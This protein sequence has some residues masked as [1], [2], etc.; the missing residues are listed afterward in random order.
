MLHSFAFGEAA[1]T[2]TA[3]AHDDPVCAMAYWGLATTAMGSLIAGRT[4]P[5]ALQKGW[6]L[7]QQAKTLGAKTPREQDYIA[8]A[9]A[10]Y[11]DADKRDR[12]QRMRAYADALEQ[13]YN[14]YPDDP[15]AQIFYGYA[16]TALAPP[17][18]KTYA[19]QLK[20][21]AVLEKAFAR[22]GRDE[23]RQI[24]APL[25]DG[26]R[27]QKCGPHLEAR[28]AVRHLFERCVAAMFHLSGSS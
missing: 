26:F 11:R 9:E 7:V 6:D 18:D 27:K 16:M 20:G 4:G 25:A 3:V 8:A 1:K 5:V 2:F 19:Y 15:E 13:I 21:A 10:F 12:D 17:T 23:C 24:D 14:K 28:N 22:R